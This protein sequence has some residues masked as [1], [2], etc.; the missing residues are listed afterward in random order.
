MHPLTRPPTPQSEHSWW[1][2][3]NPVGPTISIHAVAKPLMRLMYH[4]QVRS[5]IKK[6]RGMALSKEVVET[7]C[8][9]LAFKYISPATKTLLLKE[10]DTRVKSE[11]EASVVH[12]TLESVNTRAIYWAPWDSPTARHHG[13]WKSAPRIVSLLSDEDIEVR[14]SALHAVARISGTQEGAQAVDDTK[15]WEYFPEHLDSSNYEIRRCMC[16]ILGNLSDFLVGMLDS[17]TKNKR[18]GIEARRYA[19][20][21]LSKISSW[22]E[23][24]RAAQKSLQ[25]APELLDSFDT[26][27]RRW[28]CETLGHMMFHRVV[29]AIQL[30]GDV[31]TKVVSLVSDDDKNV[32]DGAVL[33]LSRISC[34]PDGV[35]AIAHPTILKTLTEYLNSPN[36]GI[37]QFTCNILGDLAVCQSACFAKLDFRPC[38]C[39]TR[40]L[41]DGD[42]DARRSAVYALSKMTYWR[43]VAQAVNARVMKRAPDLLDSSDTET[44]KFTCEILGNLA[45]RTSTSPLSVELCARVVSL[46]SNDD[47]GIRERAMYAI[48]KISHSPQGAA[49]VRGTRIW[50]HLAIEIRFLDSLQSRIWRFTC[51]ILGNLA[52]QESACL[53]LLGPKSYTRIVS[54]LRD[55]DLQVKRYA[56]YAVSK[57]SYWSDAAQATAD[58]KALEC[59]QDLLS[60]S[61]AETRRYTCE[62]I[63]NLTFHGS[64]QPSSELSATVVS[65]LSDN[66][67]DVRKSALYTLGKITDSTHGADAVRDTNIREYFTELLD[68]PHPRVRRLTCKVLGNLVARDII[69]P[70]LSLRFLECEPYEC[71]GITW[72]LD[73]PDI[74]VRRCAIYS[75]SRL[76][77]RPQGAQVAIDA[78]ALQ[79]VPDL[80]SSFNDETR[81]WTCEMLGHLAIHN[82]RDV[83]FCAQLVVLLSDKDRNVRQAAIWALSKMSRSVDGAQAVGDT[84]FFDYVPGLLV[85]NR[86]LTCETLDNN[87]VT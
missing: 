56:I 35:N 57:M 20:C 71:E 42:I 23:G 67:S 37:R 53:A 84:T 1:S 76:C 26:E 54:L 82:H 72:L 43:E 25:Y 31:C 81:R 36:P 8:S 6:N 68:T 59:I 65:L 30:G 79:Y 66:D 38:V 33:A 39:I 7:S 47:K 14:E 15:I 19:I 74:E 9:Y 58:T 78:G 28:T 49:V 61:D 69:S 22:S 24:A 21:A 63:G 60:S 18:T 48:A 34:S 3:R 73:D 70:G 4:E 83:Q 40:L 55:H 44:Q 50:E 2:D 64:L 75:L 87:L 10:L 11:K 29:S 51:S 16:S 41:R 45:V 27:T 46:M 5:F 86:A 32:R 62:M 80:L 52:S 13:P 12:L 17:S 85:D 77:S